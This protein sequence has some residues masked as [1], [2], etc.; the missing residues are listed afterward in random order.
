MKSYIPKAKDDLQAVSILE[1]L[2][3]EVVRMDV[4][5]LLEWVQDLRWHVSRPIGEYLAPHVNEIK[6]EILQVFSTND[7]EWKF[8]IMAGLIKQ[9]PIK[10][11]EELEMVIRRMRDNPTQREEDADLKWIAEKILN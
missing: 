9:A 11:D 6:D 10:L 5:R 3:F 1:E 2:P 7:D 4:T 8:S